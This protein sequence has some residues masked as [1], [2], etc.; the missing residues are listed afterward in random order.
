LTTAETAGNTAT[1][2]ATPAAVISA[3]APAALERWCDVVGYEGGYQV[4][5][6]GRAR[7]VD[8]VIHRRYGV[9]RYVRGQLLAPFL[10]SGKANR[11]YLC[12]RLIPDGVRETRPVHQLV[13]EAF[14]GPRPDGTLR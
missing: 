4:S 2:V 13:L 10:Y 5:D 7:S 6:M 3:R 12:V 11:C 1:V 9:V 14:V 8:R